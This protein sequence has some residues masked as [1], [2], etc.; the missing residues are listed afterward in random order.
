VS[1]CKLPV[2]ILADSEVVM[3]AEVLVPER[4]RAFGRPRGLPPSTNF[5]HPT[6][7]SRP[8]ATPACLEHSPRTRRVV[9]HP[10]CLDL[11]PL[12][13]PRTR[14]LSRPRARPVR[15]TPARHTPFLGTRAVPP[16]LPAPPDSPNNMKDMQ[17][18]IL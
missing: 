15:R 5:S 16:S 11:R 4:T 14:A 9:A 13:P 18:E 2:S 6:R 17:H 1:C 12:I 3:G 10:I 8:V 7:A